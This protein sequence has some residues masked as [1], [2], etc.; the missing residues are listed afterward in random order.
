MAALSEAVADQRAKKS[1]SGKGNTYTPLIR[2]EPKSF[3]ESELPVIKR[4]PTLKIPITYDHVNP[5]WLASTH[6]Q[7]FNNRA[8]IA[9][10]RNND[11]PGV[12]AT[13]G[14]VHDAD[15]EDEE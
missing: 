15:G 3:E 5:E 2:G 1:T 10:A 7:K 9:D 4:H 6:G 13:G 8:Y 12:I 11:G 14:A